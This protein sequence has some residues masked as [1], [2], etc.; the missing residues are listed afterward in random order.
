MQCCLWIIFL[1]SIT[2][3]FIYFA[4]SN[5]FLL[6]SALFYLHILY[7]LQIRYRNGICIEYMS[8]CISN[9]SPTDR[10]SHVFLWALV[11]SK[12]IFLIAWM[13]KKIKHKSLMP[14]KLTNNLSAVCL[15][16]YAALFICQIC[17]YLKHTL[18]F[19]VGSRLAVI[20]RRTV[21]VWLGLSVF[22]ESRKQSSLSALRGLSTRS[23]EVWMFRLPVG[24][25]MTN[26]FIFAC[27]SLNKRACECKSSMQEQNKT[28]KQDTWCSFE[29]VHAGSS[30]LSDI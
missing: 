14:E 9:V 28:V 21:Y 3:G 15:P 13:L 8:T 20:I 17:V 24:P 6:I 2:Y 4:E 25:N 10:D 30:Y 7:I 22:L 12:S 5:F 23:N 19:P 18:G 27:K 26:T 1:R 29:W 16:I 11:R